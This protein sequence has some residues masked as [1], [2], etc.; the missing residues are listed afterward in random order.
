MSEILFGLFTVHPK[1]WGGLTHETTK[2][3]G[4]CG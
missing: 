2:M 3:R 1:F 4:D